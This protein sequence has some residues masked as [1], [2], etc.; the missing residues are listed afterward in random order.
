MI[1]ANTTLAVRRAAQLVRDQAADIDL[2]F[3]TAQLCCNFFLIQELID[4][5][6][7]RRFAFG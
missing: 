7:K 2:T 3:C 5:C 1:I 4:S 6:K